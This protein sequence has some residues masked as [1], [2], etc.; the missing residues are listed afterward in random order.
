MRILLASFD[1]LATLQGGVE[2][3]VEHLTEALRA[4][5][6][7]VRLISRAQTR[8]PRLS[9]SHRTRLLL[10]PAFARAVRREAKWAEVVHSQN[11]DGAGALGVRPVVATIHTTPLDEWA[12]S[13]LGGWREAIYQRPLEAVRIRRWRRFA[14]RANHLWTGPEHVAQSL[15]QL[16]ARHVER[17]PNPVVPLPRTDKKEARRALGWD[18]RPVVLYLGRLARVKRVDRL[19][20]AMHTLPHA[21]LV[22]AGDGPERA[23]LEARAAGLP[24]TFVGRVDDRT[25]ALLLSAADAFCLPSEHEGQ[26]LALLEAMQVGVPTVATRA[27]WVPLDLAPFGLWG[28]DLP[29]LLSA[30][31]A[32]GHGP[33]APVMDYVTT[34]RRMQDGYERAVKE[35]PQR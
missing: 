22:I 18:E 8:L 3:Y 24:V 11:A 23:S 6:H 30:A 10:E 29:T 26:P 9:A 34:A 7:E 35:G 27:E 31:I 20:D 5:G 19:V 1:S 4:E 17:L 14:S 32:R 2:A 25:K 13:R 15:R 33:G 21:R 28:D 16:G 12:S